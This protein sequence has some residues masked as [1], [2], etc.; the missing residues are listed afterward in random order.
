MIKKTRIRN[1]KEL[2]QLAGASVGSTS[3]VMNGKWKKKVN[4]KMAEKILRIAKEYNYKLNPLGRSLLLKQYLRVALISEGA[5][6]EHPLLGSLSFHDFLGIAAD[7]FDSSGY[8]IDIIQMTKK[9]I[10]HIVDNGFFPEHNDAIIFLEWDIGNLRKLLKEKCPKQPFVV[11][12]NNLNTPEWSY[13]YRATEE[14][15]YKAV[16]HF[17]KNRHSKIGIS[18]VFGSNDRFKSKLAGYERALSDAGIKLNQEFIIDLNEKSPSLLNGTKLVKKFMELQ[19]MPTAFFCDDNIDAMGMLIEFEKRGVKVPDDVEII[20]YG[21]AAIADIAIKPLSYLK[22]PNVK[23]AK[24]AV[25]YIL[26]IVQNSKKPVPIQKQF[27][28]EFILQKTTR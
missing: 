5:F 20:G 15:S 8:S 3:M 25:E 27:K 23:M 11:I 14:M 24:F 16:N 21:D 22:I 4:Q 19:E 1:I 2:A 6:Q 10:N 7:K 18:R 26:D 17:I 9:K 13:I 28:E 12:G